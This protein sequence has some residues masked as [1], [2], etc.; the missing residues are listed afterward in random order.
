MG[1]I[2]DVS[3]VSINTIFEK[4]SELAHPVETHI[5]IQANLTDTGSDLLVGTVTLE[6]LYSFLKAYQKATGDL[7]QIYEKNVRRFLGGRGRVN[8]AIQRTLETHP[9]RFGLYNNGITIVVNTFMPNGK[10]IELVEPFIVNGC[11]T[12]R[13]IWEVLRRKLEAGGTGHNLE[14]EEWKQQLN[15]GVVVTKIVRVGSTG[16]SLLVEITRFT[17]SQNA[18]REKDFL[19]LVSDFKTWQKQMEDQYGIYLEIQRGGWD[20]RKAF[21]KQHPTEKQ[22]GEVANAFDLLKVFGAGWLGEAGTAFGK[23]A[24]FLPNGNIYKQIVNLESEETIFGVEDLYAAYCLQKAADSFS[25]GRGAEKITRRQTQFLFYMVL[26]DILKDVLM[27]AE[28]QPGNKAITLAIL[29]LYK[30]EKIAARDALLIAAIETIDGYL[31]NG[32]DNTIFIEPAFLVRFNQNLNS[33]LKWDQLGKSEESTPRLR[34]F[35]AIMK[36]TLGMKMGVQQ[37]PRDLIIRAIR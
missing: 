23:N 2:F 27:R 22:F 33:F 28:I 3:S 37:S 1:T 21:Q 13:T 5:P 30:P 24:P 14:L 19:A 18:V 35:L 10:E 12:T 6:N 15:K 17:N 34:A 29:E 31:T 7:D 11:Q 26:I 16:E 20:S 9:E 25:F 4:S 36:S 8:A 32:L